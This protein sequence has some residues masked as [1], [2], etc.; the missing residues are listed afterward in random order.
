MQGLKTALVSVYRKEGVIEFCQGLK[1]LGIE[2][3]ASEGTGAAL[4]GA[5][6]EAQPI[7]KFTGFSELL[8]GRVKTLHPAIFASLLARKEEPE[9]E[10]ELSQLGIP[11]IDLVVVNLY[12]FGEKS[13]EDAMELVD[14]GGCALIRAA[15]KNHARV[16]VLVDPEDYP[17]VLSQLREKGEVDGQNRARLAGKAFQHCSEYD[18]RIAAY[19]F[20]SRSQEGLFPQ[21]FL[22][23]FKK[24]GELRYG[25]NPHQRAA[26]YYELGKE[27]V[28]FGSARL[29][30]GKELSHNNIL[31]LDAALATI[32]EFE[33]TAA[34][35]I[36]HC[37]PC[38]VATSSVSIADAYR[39]AKKCDPVSA[40]GGIIAVNRPID[41]VCA[42]EILS[43]FMEAVVASGYTA[44]AL[45]V[46]KTKKN[47]RVV[48]VPAQAMRDH[49][50]V[51]RSVAGGLLVQQRDV[52]T[53]E[54]DKLRVVT[55]RAPTEEEMEALKFAW[56]VCKHVKSN[57]IVYAFKDRVVG[58]GAGQMSRVDAALL[59]WTKA[60]EGTR[61][62]VVAS[63]AFFPFRDG[64]DTVA[65]A[66]VTAIIQP[67]GSVRDQE[68]IAAANEQGLAMVFTGI[69][70][71][72]H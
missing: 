49:G 29:H 66:G 61:G 65:Q 63:D 34:V 12:P 54:E 45:K 30:Q 11:F 19:F 17:E 13:V 4:K 16:T 24:A 28:G 55:Q 52:L 57:A 9:D 25:E 64:V 2:I 31:D 58:I 40:F 39:K 8:G 5:G 68:V 42:E 56:K 53:L 72:K 22:P 3:L 38:G 69:R 67:G 43:I 48:E 7:S 44:E 60:K 20:S 35:I 10:K 27:G 71:F 50:L 26:L 47:L 15:A 51:L 62:S 23:R 14:I 32:S 37:N 46:F 21:L 33:E 36:K 1:E 18:A 59:G 70:H 6:I 41:G